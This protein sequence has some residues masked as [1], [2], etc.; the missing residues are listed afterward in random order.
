MDNI[1]RILFRLDRR[2]P[3]KSFSTQIKS[4]AH[5]VFFKFMYYFGFCMIFKD[6]HLFNV[7]A[8][9]MCVD[10][11]RISAKMVLSAQLNPLGIH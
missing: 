2:G 7:L 1:K 8:V 4:F 10:M 9:L 5:M 3:T 6:G 11:R